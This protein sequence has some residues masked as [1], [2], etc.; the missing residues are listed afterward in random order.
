MHVVWHIC[1]LR[2]TYTPVFYVLSNSNCF[3]KKKNNV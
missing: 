3:Q 2:A 1:S